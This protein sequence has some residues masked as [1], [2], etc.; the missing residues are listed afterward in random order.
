MF[1]R[2]F[3][4]YYRDI[5][6]SKGDVYPSVA[7]Q[8]AWVKRRMKDHPYADVVELGVECE[9]GYEGPDTPESERMKRPVLKKI[10]SAVNSDP[11]HKE[12]AVIL[13]P[14]MPTRYQY[15]W[16]EESIEF[17][18]AQ[19]LRI[20]PFIRESRPRK[21]WGDND[22][23]P[24]GTIRPLPETEFRL[25]WKVIQTECSYFL[26]VVKKV[27]AKL[28][29]RGVGDH[30]FGHA[31]IGFPEIDM[32]FTAG[33]IN[34]LK[35]AY[36]PE[37]LYYHTLKWM[38]KWELDA[39]IDNSISCTSHPEH[40]RDY[41]NIKRGK[42][43][44]I[45]AIFPRNGFKFSWSRNDRELTGTI[46]NDNF[47]P[48]D[49][50]DWED[51]D[52]NTRFIT[53]NEEFPFS[54]QWNDEL[55][56]HVYVTKMPDGHHKIIDD[57]VTGQEPP[58]DLSWFKKELDEKLWSADYLKVDL[59]GALR[60]EHEV[61]IA[62]AAYYA[63][64]WTTYRSFILNELGFKLQNSRYYSPL[65]LNVLNA[66]I[67]GE[68]DIKKLKLLRKESLKGTKNQIQDD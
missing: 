7:E 36:Y 35:T 65:D 31:Y 48:L 66:L 19:M 54:Y 20:H 24:P 64:D 63:L 21:P 46:W 44:K 2:P 18:G 38:K 9:N 50:D 30:D 60:S 22:Q 49:V 13:L 5:R 40:A 47:V 23:I 6:S 33:R 4:P 39:R 42:W 28:L 59:A 43:G 32:D 58:D 41:S 55:E 45:Y 34:G 15:K 61:M 12:T 53:I 29:F 16:I 57:E 14:D 52:E 25:L 26:S 27:N 51:F 1:D 11:F 3:F 17:N 10:L 68:I 67:D 37:W 8:R 56:R 62:G